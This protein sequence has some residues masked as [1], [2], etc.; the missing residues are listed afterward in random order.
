MNQDKF[1]TS[2]KD[3]SKNGSHSKIEL[4]VEDDKTKQHDHDVPIQDKRT[5]EQQTTKN[6]LDFPDEVLLCILK[7]LDKNDL[8][9]LRLCCTRFSR[10]ALDKS[11]WTYDYR[12]EPIL[13]SQMEPYETFLE[14]LTYTLAIRGDFQQY[15]ENLL[16]L[17]FFSKVK[18]ICRALRTLIIEDYYI[19]AD[20]VSF[21]CFENIY[22]IRTHT[23]NC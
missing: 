1:S 16:G 9:N 21:T 19:I 6:I 10:L 18:Q 13:P 11:L 8:K 15:S 3:K 20:E 4:E 7:N 14:P 5:N 22:T 17:L 2:F 12:K 23:T